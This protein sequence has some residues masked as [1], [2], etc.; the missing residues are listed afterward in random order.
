VDVRS[1]AEFEARRVAGALS[2]P[3]EELEDRYFDSVA[4]LD[5]A[6]P[7]VVYGAAADSFAI[8]RVAHE[9][10]DR[11]HADVKLVLCDPDELFARGVAAAEGAEAAP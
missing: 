6:Q 5:L 10:G 11:G 9:L 1:P 8:R 3:A 2:L 4:A 7:L